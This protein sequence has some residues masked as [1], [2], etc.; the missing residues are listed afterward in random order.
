MWQMAKYFWLRPL[1]TD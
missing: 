1:M